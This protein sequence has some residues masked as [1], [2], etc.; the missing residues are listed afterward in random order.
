MVKNIYHRYFFSF[1]QEDYIYWVDSTARKISRIKRDLTEREVLIEDRVVGVEGLAID[2]LA[3][4]SSNENLGHCTKIGS[5]YLNWATALKSLSA[6][7]SLK[8]N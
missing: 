5:L 8:I 2:W 7:V 6:N 1:L 4:K 3:S